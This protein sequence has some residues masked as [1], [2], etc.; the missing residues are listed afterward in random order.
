[1]L[2]K[3]MQTKI[4]QVKLKTANKNTSTLRQ[5]DFFLKKL[6][7]TIQGKPIAVFFLDIVYL[8]INKKCFHVCL[9]N[10]EMGKNKY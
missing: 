9:V 7:R 6:S 10:E 5:T 4:R 3:H 1:V 2:N 8:A